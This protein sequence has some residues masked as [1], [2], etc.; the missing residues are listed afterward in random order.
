M[1]QAREK[2]RRDF[3]LSPY[4]MAISSVSFPTLSGCFSAFRILAQLWVLSYMA[5]HV[6]PQQPH[7]WLGMK[8]M[9]HRLPSS[10][11]AGASASVVLMLVRLG[12]WDEVPCLPPT[13][14]SMLLCGWP[15]QKALVQGY[16]APSVCD[17]TFGPGHALFCSHS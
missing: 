10:A 8:C 13:S 2:V 15:S 3:R 4:P 11:P 1:G 12:G 6:V 7:V 9:G 16:E 14:F 17:I 5:L